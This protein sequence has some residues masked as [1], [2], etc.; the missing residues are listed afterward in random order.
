MQLH[1]SFI[2]IHYNELNTDE[3]EKRAKVYL[4]QLSDT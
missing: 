4:L 1:A 3:L 2:Y